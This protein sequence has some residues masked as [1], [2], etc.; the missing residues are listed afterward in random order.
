MADILLEDFPRI[1]AETFRMF[2]LHGGDEDEISLQL[3]GYHHSVRKILA[4]VRLTMQIKFH[5]LT[6]IEEKEPVLGMAF[7]AFLAMNNY[8]PQPI[9][10]SCV[11]HLELPAN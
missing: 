4:D 1:E 3:K 5:T 6:P 11:S 7:N 2:Y 8:A 9:G 10:D